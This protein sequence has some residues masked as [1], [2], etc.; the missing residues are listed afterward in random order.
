MIDRLEDRK[1]FDEMRNTDPFT[2][3]RSERFIKN[4]KEIMKTFVMNLLESK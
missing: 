3:F 1:A 4:G 2:G